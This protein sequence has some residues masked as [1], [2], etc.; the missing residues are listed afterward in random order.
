MALAGCTKEADTVPVS[1]VGEPAGLISALR[2]APGAVA[3]QD[4]TR[5]SRCV[6]TARTDADLQSLGFSLGR[7]ADLLRGRAATDTAAAL[8]LGYLAGA[9]RA[10]ARAATSGI[11][12]QLGRRM[13]QLATLRPGASPAAVAAWARG[14][15]AGESDG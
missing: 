11:A 14:A 8:Q 12:E 3:L 13:G 15:R 4:G 5:L 1:C 7:T 10:G 2:Q 6:S 9:V